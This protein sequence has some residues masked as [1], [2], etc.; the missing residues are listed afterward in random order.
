MGETNQISKVLET[1][2]SDTQFVRTYGDLNHIGAMR[3]ETNEVIPLPWL[4]NNDLCR[5]QEDEPFW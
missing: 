5:G 3:V 4:F 1:L 2:F